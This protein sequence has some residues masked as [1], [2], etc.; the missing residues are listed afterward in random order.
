MYLEFIV[1]V[2][3][4]AIVMNRSTPKISKTMK[5]ISGIISTILVFFLSF[6]FFENITAKTGI[7]ESAIN[8][9]STIETNA[10][11]DTVNNKK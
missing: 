3:S 7:I 11:E 1:T 4:I 8:D 9:F 10:I 5:V 6:L 2:R